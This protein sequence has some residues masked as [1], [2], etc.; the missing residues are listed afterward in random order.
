MRIEQMP[1]RRNVSS[2]RLPCYTDVATLIL[3]TFPERQQ[4]RTTPARALDVTEQERTRPRGV[5]A[6]AQ[7]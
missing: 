2:G 5:A 3:K 7:E 1:N 4:S 6:Y